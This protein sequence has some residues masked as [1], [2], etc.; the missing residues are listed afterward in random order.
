MNKK[1]FY[2]CNLPHYNTPGQIY[3]VTW[4]LET[5]V[6]KKAFKENAIKLET[7][8]NNL[9]FAIQQKQSPEKIQALKEQHQHLIKTLNRKIEKILHNELNPPIDLRKQKNKK[10]IIETLQFWEGK[11]IENIAWSIMPNHVHWIFFVKEKN[12]NDQPVYLKD[13]LHSVKLFTA[14]II[15]TN[16]KRTGRLWSKESFDTT[17]RNDKHLYNVVNYT[18][19]NPVK[20]GFTN[21]WKNWTGNFINE[22]YLDFVDENF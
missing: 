7:L 15:N 5:S 20:A 11:K 10:T 21:S 3:F 12:T 22:Q 8:K 2:R 17:V 6:P 14:R 4:I 1:E 13:I 19:Q 16:E 18:L 9:E